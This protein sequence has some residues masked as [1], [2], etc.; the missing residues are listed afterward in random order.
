M[1]GREG[2]GCS[3]VGSDHS[4][5]LPTGSLSLLP[6]GRFALSE[7]LPLAVQSPVVSPH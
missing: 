5:V 1:L 2:G 3:V 4:T 6:E 7:H